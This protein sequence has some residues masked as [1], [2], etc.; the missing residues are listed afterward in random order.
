MAWALEFE[1]TVE[2][3]WHILKELIVEEYLDGLESILDWVILGVGIDVSEGETE[4]VNPIPFLCWPEDEVK[5]SCRVATWR[6]WE[7]FKKF[8]GLMWVEEALQAVHELARVELG[9]E[10]RPWAHIEEAQ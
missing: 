1:D 2:K 8:V 9:S 10:L 5:D 4:Q 3:V 6:G 7:A